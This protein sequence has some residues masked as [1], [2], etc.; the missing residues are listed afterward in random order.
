AQGNTVSG[1]VF[2][3][4]RTP[5]YDANV[6]LLDEFSR[7][8]SRGRTDNSGR[9]FLGGVPSGR[10]IIRVQA[11][12]SDYEDQEQTVEIVNFARETATG[13]LR[14]SGFS[15][16]QVDFYLKPRKGAV[17]IAEAIFLQDVPPRAKGLYDRGIEKLSRREEKEGLNNIKAAI[18]A[19]PQ[20]YAALSRLGTEYVRLQHYEAARILLAVAVEINPRGQRAWYGLAYASNALE[21]F[22]EAM[23]AVKKAV[24]LY[25]KSAEALLLY[26]VLLRR[27][28][29]YNEAAIQMLKSI[30]S[31]G[32]LLPAAHWQLA[33]LYGNDLK[34]FGDAAKQL[35][36]F[37]KAQPKAEDAENIKKLITE[38][39]TK[40]REQG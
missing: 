4:E 28:K 2:G 35:R 34:R 5:I 24:E 11:L 30:E 19:F 39:E 13:Q 25:D 20:Y 14:L 18:E 12:A 22:D 29:Q 31:A 6:E 16:E 17:F 10:L 1:Y 38:L 9:Y 33:L 23:F 26:G 3:V 36:L 27:Q 40:A 7:T 15:N 32:G 37:L 8:V 21:R